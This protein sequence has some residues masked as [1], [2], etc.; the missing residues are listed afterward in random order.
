MLKESKIYILV[1]DNCNTEYPNVQYFDNHEYS[2]VQNYIDYT[3]QIAEEEG[4]IKI[5]KE[6][7]CSECYTL[8]EYDDV[9][10]KLL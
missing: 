8:D 5:N 6:H 4:W 10:I 2:D 1:C 7:Y 9:Q 3:E